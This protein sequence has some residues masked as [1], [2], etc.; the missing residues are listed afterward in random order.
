MCG[1]AITLAGCGGH[2]KEWNSKALNSAVTEHLRT[3]YPERFR[4]ACPSDKTLHP[5]DKIFCPV[6]HLDPVQ[7]VEVSADSNSRLHFIDSVHL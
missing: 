2:D 5:G 3:I 7:G 6:F 1:V 4:V